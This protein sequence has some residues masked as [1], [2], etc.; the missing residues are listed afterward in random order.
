V[1]GIPLPEYD[2][3]IGKIKFVKNFYF[4]SFENKSCFMEGLS[5][6]PKKIAGETAVEYVASGMTVGLGTGSTAYFAIQ[7]I[8]SR[9]KDGLDIKAVATSLATEKMAHELGIKM[10]SLQEVDQIDITIDGADE[11]SHS[12]NLIKGGGGA[13]LREKIVGAATRRYIIIADYTKYVPVLGAF[14]LP[15]EVVQFGW[16]M[17]SRHLKALGCNPR[18]RQ[19]GNGDFVSENGNFI[20]DCSFNSIK[21]PAMLQQQINAIPGVVENGLFLKMANM[22]IIGEKEGGTTIYLAPDR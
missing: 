18:L 21:D 3:V 17:T 12:L 5:I 8:G 16:Q 6:D 19:S 11:V 9:V 4:S 1:S 15:V 20:L 22:V 10:I 14:P 2:A 13:L 7:A